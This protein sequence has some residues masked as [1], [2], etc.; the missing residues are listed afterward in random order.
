MRNNSKTSNGSGFALLLDMACFLKAVAAF[1]AVTAKSS[2]KPAS[3][4]LCGPALAFPGQFR[5]KSPH[6]SAEFVKFCAFLPA[7]LLHVERTFHLDHK[8]PYPSLA[9][10]MARRHEAPAERKVHRHPEFCLGEVHGSPRHQ[11]AKWS[12]PGSINAT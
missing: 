4:D 3:I 5:Y 11:P 2:R 8:R 7:G 6:L 9:P 1:A 10:I 12:R